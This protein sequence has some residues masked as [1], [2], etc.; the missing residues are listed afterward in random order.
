M[1]L[2][3]IRIGLFISMS[4]IGLDAQPMIQSITNNSLFLYEVTGHSDMS[5]CS[6]F[7][8][9]KTVE[10]KPL[11]KYE[12][13]FLLGS[14]KPGLRLQPIAYFDKH[15]SI[16]YFFTDATGKFNRQKMELAFEMWQKNNG[17]MY[18][19]GFDHWLENWLCGD[20]SLIHN[21]VEVFGY[22]LN[23]Q[24]TKI[25]NNKNYHVCM[26]DFSEGVFSRL[27]IDI[28]IEQKRSKGII[29][30]V[31]SSVGQGGYCKDGTVM[32]MH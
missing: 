12:L 6:D 25:E 2:H 24:L 26:I 21:H 5:G 1:K 15:T 28:T 7:N 9:G 8:A 19:K 23:V 30:H 10:I 22:L 17:K 32:I 11:S 27:F 18:K 3:I 29:P 13:P 16:Y 4:F 20:I 31:K 14:E